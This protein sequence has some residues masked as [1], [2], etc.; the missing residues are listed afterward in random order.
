MQTDD[1]KWATAAVRAVLA[2]CFC[3][4]ALQMEMLAANL[5]MEMGKRRTRL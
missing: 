4:L 1:T 3:A 5:R 2:R